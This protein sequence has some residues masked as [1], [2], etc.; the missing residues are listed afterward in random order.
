[1]QKQA[2]VNPSGL[3]LKQRRAVN[4]QMQPTQQANPC[5]D[6]VSDKDEGALNGHEIA[7]PREPSAKALLEHGTATPPTEQRMSGRANRQAR[8]GHTPP[9]VPN[10]LED[11]KRLRPAPEER[12]ARSGGDA[13][14]ERQAGGGWVGNLPQLRKSDVGVDKW[15]Q[16]CESVEDTRNQFSEVV[17]A[18]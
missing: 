4:L 11:F 10:P 9:I 16:G 17:A 7:K 5:P 6:N 1:M 8:P 13:F 12:G 18:Y 15:R 2:P 3:Y 14:S